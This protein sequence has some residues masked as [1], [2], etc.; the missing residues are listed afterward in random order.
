MH[1]WGCDVVDIVRVVK[2][3]VRNLEKKRDFEMF[4]ESLGGMF[5]VGNKAKIHKVVS[6][7]SYANFYEVRKELP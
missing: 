2:T 5:G 4:W 7:Y 1:V 6:P 3:T